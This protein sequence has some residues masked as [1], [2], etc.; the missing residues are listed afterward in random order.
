MTYLY[1]I[2]FFLQVS[3]KLYLVQCCCH[4]IYEKLDLPFPGIFPGS[5]LQDKNTF[6]IS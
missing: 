6:L 1:L 3:Y 2:T 5:S 4:P